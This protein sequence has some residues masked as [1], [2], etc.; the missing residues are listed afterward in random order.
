MSSDL[1][2][3]ID[4]TKAT[5]EKYLFMPFLNPFYDKYENDELLLFTKNF[6]SLT[7]DNLSVVRSLETLSTKIND[8]EL[9]EIVTNS[10]V[11]VK[12]SVPLHV[13]FKKHIKV[14][15]NTYCSLIEKGEDS[16]Y[17]YKVLENL[18]NLLEQS[19]DLKKELENTFSYVSKNIVLFFLEIIFLMAFVVPPFSKL[20][21]RIN[22]PYLTELVIKIGFWF[23]NNV[24]EIFVVILITWLI[25]F[26]INQTKMGKL[27]L[28]YLKL[29]IPFFGDLLKKYS[30]ITYFRNLV[31]CFS[32]GI[33]IVTSIKLSNEIVKNS[34]LKKRLEQIPSYITEEGLT[35]S[36]S[37]KKTNTLSKKSMMIINTGEESGHIDE[38]FTEI[39][40]SYEKESFD[41]IRQIVSMVKPIGFTIMSI[42]CGTVLISMFIPLLEL[43]KSLYLN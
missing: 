28:D 24:I 30:L 43:I 37:F 29:K 17:L 8:K 6:A 7:K 26:L 20:Y 31:T 11:E 23:Q 2:N 4:K 16:G 41:K 34:F 22:K 14:F 40:D 9:K 33:N 21:E 32:S 1:P 27:I 12:E 38:M 18:T 10:I 42:I 36:E 25:I 39:A 15:G 13:C 35:I 3:K 5:K 19:K